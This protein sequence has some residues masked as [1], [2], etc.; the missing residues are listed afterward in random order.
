MS[1]EIRPASVREQIQQKARVIAECQSKLPLIAGEINGFCS[2]GRLEGEAYGAAKGHMQQYVGLVKMF[3]VAAE[4]TRRADN[5]VLAALDRFGGASVVS[6]QEWIQKKKDAN[7]L[8]SSL[9]GRLESLR[10]QPLSPSTGFMA[11][12]LQ[13]SMAGCRRQ[14]SYAE[15]MLSKIYS[16]CAETNSLYEGELHDLSV[17]VASGVRAFSDCEFDSRTGEW[18]FL[19][20][21]WMSAFAIVEKNRD[22]LLFQGYGDVE[23]AVFVDPWL[24]PIKEWVSGVLSEYG[25]EIQFVIGG[26]CVLVGLGLM[27]TAVGAPAGLQLVGGGGLAMCSAYSSKVSGKD[28]DYEESLCVGVGS[29]IGVDSSTMKNVLLT[30]SVLSVSKT[31]KAGYTLLKYGSFAKKAKTGEMV[32]EGFVPMESKIKL[33]PDADMVVNEVRSDNAEKFLS[34]IQ[35]GAGL[36]IDAASKPKIKQRDKE[37]DLYASYAPAASWYAF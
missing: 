4:L 14:A 19:D 18:G 25:N 24:N 13:A 6:E 15:D 3:H 35:S 27:G 12:S 20:K 11:A 17:A 26:V 30:S 16:Y 21:S 34:G 2:S 33:Q 31:P 37:E 32:A 23:K 29:W 5:R 9:N 28:I 1:I 22:I 8:L 10:N 36:A 7:D